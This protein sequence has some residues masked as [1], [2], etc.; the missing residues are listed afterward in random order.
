MSW[1]VYLQDESG[2]A[3]EV[4]IHTEGGTIALGGEPTAVLNV[5]YNY[6]KHFSAAWDGLRFVPALN[7]KKAADVIALLERG[8]EK[9]GDEPDADYWAATPGNAGHALAILLGWARQH[10]SARFFVS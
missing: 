1:D 2:Q 9:L 8:V 5:T 6:S 3:V 10:P 4:P 7:G